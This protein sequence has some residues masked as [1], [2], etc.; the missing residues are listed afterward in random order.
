MAGALWN[1]LCCG[2]HILCRLVSSFIFAHPP[3]STPLPLM[4]RSMQMSPKDMCEG[5][6]A[7]RG[8]HSSNSQR[9]AALFEAASLVKV[10]ELGATPRLQFR[11]SRSRDR[12]SRRC[13][14]VVCP[15]PPPL[16]SHWVDDCSPGQTRRSAQKLK[17]LDG[18]PGRITNFWCRP[19]DFTATGGESHTKMNSEF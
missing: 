2:C 10:I 13:S 15:P 7:L 9:H 16:K 14:S 8:P 18:K 4:S 12:D 11:R 1:A 19:I 17:K 6:S 5:Q 3:S